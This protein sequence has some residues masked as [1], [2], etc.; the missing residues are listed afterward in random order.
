MARPRCSTLAVIAGAVLLAAWPGAPIVPSPAAAVP[1]ARPTALRDVMPA[2]VLLVKARTC[3]NICVKWKPC[4]PLPQPQPTGCLVG[5]YPN[6]QHL[7]QYCAKYRRVCSPPFGTHPP[8]RFSTTPQLLGPR[9]GVP[10]DAPAPV[11][12]PLRR[13]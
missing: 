7:D 10:R 4:P 2:A 6:I 5:T 11:G 3:K 13:R 8:N 9:Q 12:S 1:L